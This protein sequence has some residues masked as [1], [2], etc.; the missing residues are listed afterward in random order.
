[1]L[2]LITFYVRTFPLSTLLIP[3]F[4]LERQVHRIILNSSFNCLYINTSVKH[5]KEL[6]SGKGKEKGKR[7]RQDSPNNKNSTR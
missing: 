3:R 5:A 1:M 2:K 4:A 7:K 6:S